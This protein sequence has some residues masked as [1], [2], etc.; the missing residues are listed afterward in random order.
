LLRGEDGGE[1]DRRAHHHVQKNG[2]P[3]HVASSRDDNGIT[4]SEPDQSSVSSTARTALASRVNASVRQGTAAATRAH[5]PSTRASARAD[6]GGGKLRA[7][8]WAAAA[9]SSIAATR[10]RGACRRKKTADSAAPSGRANRPEPCQGVPYIQGRPPWRRMTMRS[11]LSTR[12]P[13]WCLRHSLAV[14]VLPAPEW[15]QK[16]SPWPS[17]TRP[18]PWTTIAPRC[19]K[20]CANRSSSSG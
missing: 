4:V 17:A 15:P 5:A 18:Q 1:R 6:H 12:V 11:S 8:R 3:R 7:N 10:L 20:W 2:S 14:V 9:G 19:A 13:R 16:S